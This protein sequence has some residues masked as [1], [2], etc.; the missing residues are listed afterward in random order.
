M[1]MLDTSP[2][3]GYTLGDAAAE[4]EECA[5]EQQLRARIR[6]AAI[7]RVVL[8]GFKTPLRVIA[9]SIC[10]SKSQ[11]LQSHSPNTWF[12]ARSEIESFAPDDGLLVR[13]WSGH[14]VVTR[15]PA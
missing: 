6:Y 14:A 11:A 13:G 7:V 12:A 10:S 9:D 3:T 4:D 8:R 15:S 5:V 1:T 2:N